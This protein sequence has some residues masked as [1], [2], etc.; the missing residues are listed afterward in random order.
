MSTVEGREE[1]REAVRL[2]GM[3][4]SRPQRC[5]ALLAKNEAYGLD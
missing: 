4:A 1:L 2:A 3:N 5:H